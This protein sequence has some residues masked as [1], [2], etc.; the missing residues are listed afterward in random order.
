MF[1]VCL[2]LPD[3]HEHRNRQRAFRFQVV[4]PLPIEEI[5]SRDVL[6]MDFLPG[7]KFLTTIR[8]CARTK[9]I[10]LLSKYIE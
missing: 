3:Q 8:V 5:C 1:S 7:K 2:P 4:V 10:T 6:V 9:T